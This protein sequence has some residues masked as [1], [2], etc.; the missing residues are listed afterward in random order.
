MQGCRPKRA[1]MAA[2]GQ[3]DSRLIFMP[4]RARP[5][6]A[7]LLSACPQALFVVRLRRAH[8][9]AVHHRLLRRAILKEQHRH[10]AAAVVS[11]D[12]LQQNAL[13]GQRMCFAQRFAQ[14]TQLLGNVGVLRL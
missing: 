11:Q 7:H 5:H 13:V 2:Q 8:P 1:D 9:L 12:R 3:K 14:D 10:I 4:P 6:R